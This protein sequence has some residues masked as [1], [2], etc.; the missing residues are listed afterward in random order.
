MGFAVNSKTM[1]VM[2]LVYH[3]SVWILLSYSLYINV[4]EVRAEDAP[5]VLTSILTIGGYG[6]KFKYLTFWYFVSSVFNYNINVLCTLS[7][8]PRSKELIRI[9]PV[10]KIAPCLENNL[11]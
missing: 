9:L 11:K 8:F 1:A 4:T 3:L 7:Q 2:K 6:G 10:L 5:D